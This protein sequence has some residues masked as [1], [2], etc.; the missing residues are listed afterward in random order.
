MRLGR[1]ALGATL[2]AAAI[3]AGCSTSPY[4]VCLVDSAY[5]RYVPLRDLEDVDFEARRLVTAASTAELL[6]GEAQQYWF[7][8]SDASLLLCRQSRHAT[9]LCFSTIESFTKKDGKWVGSGED[10]RYCTS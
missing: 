4:R 7:K 5:W 9:N 1:F 8:H 10:T 3:T 6:H 2:A